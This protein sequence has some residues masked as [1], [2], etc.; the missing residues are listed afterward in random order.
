MNHYQF[1]EKITNVINLVYTMIFFPKARLIR[2]PFYLRGK[3]SFGYGQGFTCGYGCRFDLSNDTKLSLVLGAN[4]LI[5]DYVHIVAL[6][7]VR[8]GDNCLLASKV[9]ISDTNHGNLNT[10][11][12]NSSPLIPVNQRPLQ[13]KPVIIGKNVWIGEAVSILPGV[14]IGD[15]VIIGAQSVVTNNIPAHS[16]VVGVP[17]RVIKT[18]DFEHSL[19]V[20]SS[21]VSKVEQ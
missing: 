14:T 8:I 3:R 6:D 5:G 18:Y 16:M 7:S 21:L 11:D 13:T 2:R 12:P 20:N 17:A 1:S 19:W 15:G 10:S 9:F 4:V